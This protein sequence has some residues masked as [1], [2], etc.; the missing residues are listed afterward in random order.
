[1]RLLFTFATVMTLLLTG[2][3]KAEARY[4]PVENTY[5][6][7]NATAETEQLARTES[8]RSYDLDYLR[9]SVNRA[10]TANRANFYRE[11]AS[12]REPRISIPSRSSFRVNMNPAGR[13]AR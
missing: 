1:M 8:A 3:A 7:S 11:V 6:Y 5:H 9:A 4:M 13:T 10:H 12:Y 2:E